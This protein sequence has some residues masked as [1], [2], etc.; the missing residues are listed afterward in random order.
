M[1]FGVSVGGAL[2][3]TIIA[4]LQPA[5]S[6]TQ[7][8]RLSIRYVEDAVKK[9][10]SLGARCGG[11]ASAVSA[12]GGRLLEKAADRPA[13]A[14]REKLR[15]A[16]RERRGSRRRTERSS[17]MRVVAGA[18]RI[19][20]TLHGS[21]QA[22]GMLLIVPKDAALRVIDIHGEHVVA[23]KDNNTYT[24]L[25]CVSRDCATETVGLEF[26]SRRDI[27]LTL[28]EDRYGAPDFA[29]KL[30]AARPKNAIPSQNGDVV[31]LVNTIVV[32]AK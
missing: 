5:Y 6:R 11:T 21:P 14:V 9:K 29:A 4:G 12:R 7:A 26:G 24:V 8:Q 32:K 18:H 27:T 15:R 3:A 23:P 25:A 17:P 20:I 10:A 31:A 1:I 13:T 30:V 19:T 2:I 28:V 22:S 16:G